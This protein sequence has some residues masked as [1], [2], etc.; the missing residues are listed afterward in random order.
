MNPGATDR[1]RGFSKEDDDE[2][3]LVA[4]ARDGS[5]EALA[6]LCRA[7]QAA[8]RAYTR[9]CVRDPDVG[10]D[11]AQETFV[12]AFRSLDGFRN[13]ARFRTWVL[14]IARH[15]VQDHL[16]QTLRAASRGPVPE[17]LAR[18]ELSLVEAE[19]SGV[20]RRDRELAALEDCVGRLPERAAELVRQHYFRARS[21]VDLAQAQG[22]NQVTLRV[23]LMRIRLALRRCVE[24]KLAAE[25]GT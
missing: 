24:A 13:A 7:H 21:L 20:L 6:R 22:K 9:S 12:A 19:A 17:A 14:G 16:R 10:D 2:A 18:R 15:R 23:E 4:A 1:S 5:R 3:A 8:V 11:L 25:A